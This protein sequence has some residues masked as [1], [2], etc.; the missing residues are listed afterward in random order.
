[1]FLR[2]FAAAL[3]STDLVEFIGGSPYVDGITT[4]PFVLDRDGYL[5]IP[6]IGGLGVKLDREKLARY[7]PQPAL[8]FPD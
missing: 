5:A 1:M 8:L 6:E 2:P 3:P 4:E 7:T